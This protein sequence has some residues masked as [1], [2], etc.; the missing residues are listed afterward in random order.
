MASSSVNTIASNNGQESE[1]LTEALLEREVSPELRIKIGSLKYVNELIDF[2]SETG[3]PIEVKS[4]QE[5]QSRSDKHGDKRLG[6]F[7]LDKE[8]HRALL[9][10]DGYY[11]FIV[12]A[13]SLV[14]RA[15]L[16]K[17]DDIT[18]QRLKLWR[19]LWS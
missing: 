11:F 14:L 10:K 15:K 16:M 6:R 18:F 4:C 3:V 13:G 5:W 2:Y 7:V 12:K 8:Q 1:Y 9:C 17:A 19:P